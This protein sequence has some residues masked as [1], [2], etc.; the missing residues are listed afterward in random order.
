MA[1]I[2]APGGGSGGGGGWIY[3]A[4]VSV[5]G[6]T[7][8]SKVYQDSGN[9]IL[10]SATVSDADVDIEV[11]ASFPLVTVNGEDFT[12]NRDA[13]GGYYVGTVSTTLG[14]SGNILGTVKTPDGGA[15]ATDTLDLTIDAP[16]TITQLNF[17]GSYP[18][19]QT[20]LKEND[21]FDLV[22]AADKNFDRIEIIDFEASKSKIIDLGATS[23]PT[24]VQI[25]AADRGDTPQQLA[26][27]V[28][29]RDATTGAFSSTRDTN[30]GGGSTDG[31]H[32]VTLNNLHPSGSVSSV[33]YPG[34]QGALKGAEQATVN[35]TASDYDSIAYTDPTGAQISIA[36]PATFE[37]AKTVTSQSS[38][39]FNDS[40]TNFRYV[41]TR[42]ANGAQT[43][44]NGVVIIAD[45]AATIT[46]T[47]AA[48]RLRSGGNNGT[49]PQDHTITITS[50]QPLLSAPSLSPD[51]GGNRGAF[52][53]GGFTG[54]PSVWTRSLRVDETVPD[55]KGTFTWES[56]SATNLAGT[57]TN[58][59]TGDAQYTLGGF[60][61]RDLPFAAYQTETSIGTSVEDFSK[62]TAGIFTATNQASVK[63][64]IGTM[65][66]VTNGYTIDATG[67]NPTTL[68]WLDTDA[69]ATN[70][71]GTAQIENVEETV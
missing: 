35:H 66:P 29:V 24:T 47:E 1:E 19:S 5:S 4:D 27:R 64:S 68:E 58:A 9:T 51:S 32:V 55:E 30:T 3:F 56:L 33:D 69:A 61:S 22:V 39:V 31:T 45:V 63:Q 21:S 37:A 7:T 71:T 13:G 38:G 46:V 26:A 44:V 62:L 28:R 36:N 48:A 59:I 40:S 70:S 65:P 50:D 11:R 49:A 16:P 6:G 18:G 57:V 14:G 12:L 34:G 10:N 54:G 60:V 41:L 53:G 2:R 43:T 15:G 42:D 17:S 52:Q 67:V 20:E 8:T 23:G 25:D